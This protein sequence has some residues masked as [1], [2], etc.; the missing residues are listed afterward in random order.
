MLQALDEGV[1]R[2]SEHVQAREIHSEKAPITVLKSVEL[3]CQGQSSRERACELVPLNHGQ[4]IG[5]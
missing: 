5:R 4:S 3:R 2:C 1:D